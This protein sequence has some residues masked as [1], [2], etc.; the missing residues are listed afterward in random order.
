MSD[1]SHEPRLTG[2]LATWGIVPAAGAAS[3]LQ[4]LALSKELLPVGGRVEQGVER[5]RAISEYLVERLI[6]GGATKLCF[7]VSPLKADIMQYYGSRD[8]GAEIVYATQ[9]RPLGLCDALFRAASL[10]SEDDHVLIGLPDTIWFPEDALK[11]LPLN[12]LS[13]LLFPVERPASFDAVVTGDDGEVLEIQ[14]KHAN[15]DS[16]WIWGAMGMPGAIFHELHALWQSPGRHDE[17]LG[18]LI[19]AWLA[20]GG[21]ANGV[22][23]GGEYIDAGTLEGYRAAVQLLRERNTACEQILT[24][25]KK[26]EETNVLSSFTG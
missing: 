26:E 23:G 10:V 19:N 20:G 17:Y 7:V 4:P 18:T 6:R 2:H 13:L 11:H 16:C 21:A 8:W 22:R 25:H 24:S 15:P 9:P 14:V 3:R 5:P 12:T 1:S